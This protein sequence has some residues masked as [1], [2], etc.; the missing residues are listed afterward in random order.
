M[1]YPLLRLWDCSTRD[2]GLSLWKWP[3][4]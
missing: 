4:N 3:L 2:G 1:E